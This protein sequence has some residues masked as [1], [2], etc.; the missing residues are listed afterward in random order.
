MDFHQ[1]QIRAHMPCLYKSARPTTAETYHPLPHCVHIHCL[2]SRNIQKAPK[3]ASGCHL[4][5]K[6]EFSGAVFLRT[7]FHVRHH[8]VRLHSAA[9]CHT[10]TKLTVLA[11]RSKFPAVPPTSTSDF[12]GQHN[13]IG[14]IACRAALVYKQI[15]WVLYCSKVYV[16]YV[17]FTA[18][19]ILL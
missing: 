9:I 18:W 8:F 17:L 12:T 19:L 13:Q 10:A 14:D 15:Y 1:L 2:V 4:F 16:L 5:L 6:E 7:H 11:G 3:N